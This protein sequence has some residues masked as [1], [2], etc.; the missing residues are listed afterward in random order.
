MIVMDD[1]T[2]NNVQNPQ[3]ENEAVQ[4]APMQDE[5]QMPVEAA[6]TEEAAPAAEEA[7]QA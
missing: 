5:A 4:A 1:N 3:G 7:P 6:P 2:Q